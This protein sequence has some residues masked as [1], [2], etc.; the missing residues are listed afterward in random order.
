MFNA[1]FSDLM[2]SKNCYLSKLQSHGTA[3]S[4]AMLR[5]MGKRH[6]FVKNRTASCSSSDASDDEENLKRRMGKI[7]PPNPRRKDGDNHDGSGGSGNNGEKIVTIF[8]SF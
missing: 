8:G 2:T 4:H 3:V 5:I 1:R 6:K 7:K